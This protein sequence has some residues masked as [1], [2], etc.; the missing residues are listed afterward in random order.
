MGVLIS[1]QYL[2]N[3]KVK[4]KHEESGKEFITSA[5]RDNQGDS[6]SFSPTD[7]AGSSL[8]SCMLTIMSILAEREEIDLS[9]S[10]FR[11]EKF[12]AENPRRIAELKVEFFLPQRL[13]DKERQKLENAAATCPV[14][15][16]VHPDLKL[17][18]IYNYCV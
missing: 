14:K 5:P 2:G 16:S 12:M 1:G 10:G 15:R 4:L 7:L 8:A 18:L 11:V 3:K 13:S 6:S 9:G 17:S